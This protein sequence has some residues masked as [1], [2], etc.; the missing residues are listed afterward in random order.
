MSSTVIE[1]T[2]TTTERWTV[3]PRRTTVEFEVNH[4]WGLHT[5]RG[6]FDRFDGSYTVGFAGPQ[7][8]LTIDAASVDTGNA[9]RDRHLRS[10][11]FFD[12]AEHPKVRFRSTRILPAGTERVHVSGTL[13]AAGTS[14]PVAFEASVR[15][16]DGELE[17]EAT[18]TVDQSRL[19]M[20]RGPLGNVRPPA[21]LHVKARVLREPSA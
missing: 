9:A 18:T 10:E 3:D 16:I 20:S 5:V 14:V 6:R 17:I 21:K 8:E 19:G 11:D 2:Q 12:V 4:F 1:S 15:L 7:V 13:T